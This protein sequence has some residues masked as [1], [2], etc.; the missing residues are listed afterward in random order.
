M[1]DLVRGYLPLVAFHS[2]AP[3]L[4]RNALTRHDGA[5]SIRRAYTP[6]EL[7]HMA[8]QAGIENARVYAYFPWRMTL[9][10]EKAHV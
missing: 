8:R 5:L 3:L 2:I 4:A 1:S 7:A 6:D 9:V 10:V